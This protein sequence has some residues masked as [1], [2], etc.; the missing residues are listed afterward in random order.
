MRREAGQGEKGNGL[1]I[2]L[3]RLFLPPKLSSPW[4][5]A[6]T[7]N[8]FLKTVSD[9]SLGARISCLSKTFSLQ[10]QKGKG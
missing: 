10:G 4:A 1:K 9:T 6:M 3:L 8:V 2:I 7:I 5:V